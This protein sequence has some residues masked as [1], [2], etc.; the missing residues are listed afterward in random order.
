MPRTA[1]LSIHG[2]GQRWHGWSEMLGRAG[3]RLFEGLG[4]ALV[5]AGVSLLLAL[6]TYSPSDVSLDTAVD[7]APRNF[8]GHDGALVADLLVQSVGLAAYL[9]PAVLFGW[10]F[11][12]MLARPIRRPLRGTALLLLGLVLGAAACSILR[13]GLSLPA[14]AGGVVGWL[15]LGLAERAGL[16]SLALP[17]AMTAAAL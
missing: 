4:I 1:Q 13:P 2:F 5:L 9:V 8:L 3:Q 10:A 15:L 7:A 11:R 12:L 16:A 17:L 14:G 6:L